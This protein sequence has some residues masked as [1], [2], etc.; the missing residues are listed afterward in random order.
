[1]RSRK[2]RRR[3][4]YL[5]VIIGILFLAAAGFAGAWYFSSQLLE[6][7]H[8]KTRYNVLVR[9]RSGRV[10]TLSPVAGI[11]DRGEFGLD[12]SHGHTLV[13]PA[14]GAT[15]TGITRR[16]L[17]PAAGLRSGDHVR[18]DVAVYRSPQDVGLPYRKITFPSSL[19]PMPAWMVSG[20]GST[21]VIAV[22]GMGS[23]PAETIRAM[24]ALSSL[25]IR[26]M[27]IEY[28]NDQRAPA[29]PDHLYH[30]GDTEWMDLEAAV[31]YAK[32]HG[33]RHVILYGYSMG[34]N[35]VETFLERSHLAPMARVVILDAPALDWYQILEQAAEQRNLPGVF[36]AL[37][38]RVVAWRIGLFSLDPIDHLLSGK[39]QVPPTLIFQGTRDTL[40]PPGAT[41]RY[42]EKYRR[43]VTYAAFAGAG[44]VQSWNV[45]PRRYERT[46]AGFLRTRLHCARNGRTVTCQ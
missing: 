32:K 26:I 46:L 25:G 24:P 44:H 16:L 45:N 12:W 3:R 15:T 23:M 34:G 13:G 18:Y 35:I 42:A 1:M 27:A 9:A 6:V 20:R 11:A 8:A 5:V 30:L 17:R 31:R 21:W 22:H 2:A 19:G 37:V 38:E 28:R 14:I 36:A 33:A 43:Y 41:K 10:V 29:S 7:V 40:V 39:A 4:R